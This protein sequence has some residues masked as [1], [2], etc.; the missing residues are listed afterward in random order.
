MAFQLQGKDKFSK[1]RAGTLKT[2]HGEIE[3]PIF[4][5]VGTIGSVKAIHFKEL[6][7]EINAQIILGITQVVSAIIL[8]FFVKNFSMKNQ[9][10]IIIYWGVTLFYG[11]LYLADFL[12]KLDSLWFVMLVFIPLGIAG[13]FT[14]I[15]ESIKREL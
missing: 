13:Y 4:M 2:D 7:E 8:L 12:D 6:E 9:N 10:R 1:A 11:L 14:F 15:L 5:P 3:T